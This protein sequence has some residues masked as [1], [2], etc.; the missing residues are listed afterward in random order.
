[1][2]TSS[3]NAPLNSPSAIPHGAHWVRFNRFFGDAMMI[4][5]A[6]APLRAAGLPLVAWGPAAVIDLFDGSEGFVAVVP[7]PHR[8]YSPWHAA[9]MLRAHRPASIINFPKSS[10]ALLAARLARVPKRLG[11]AEG[12]GWAL[13]THTVSFYRQDTPFVERYAGVVRRAFPELAPTPAFAPFRPRP[14]AFDRAKAQAAQ[15]RFRGPYVVFAPGANS[16]AKRLSVDAFATLGERLRGEGLGVVVLGAGPRDRELVDRLR[17][18]LPEALDLVDRC[19]LSTSAAW[20]CGAKG[21]VGMD[22][23]LAHVAAAAGI[24]TLSVFGP[25]RPR[26][27][28]PAGPRSRV[29]RKTELACLECMTFFCPVSGHPCMNGWEAGRLWRELEVTLNLGIP[30]LESASA[31]G[32]MAFE[33]LPPVSRKA[34]PDERVARP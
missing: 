29:I 18:R 23:G 25:T 13:S 22:S 28:Q 24:P 5:A 7:E 9:D 31:A 26:H 8:K 6:I 20:I 34:H 11:C 17:E 30:S 14:A 4:H 12:G 3:G 2:K 21:L 10:R 1:M 16:D 33:F 15:L 32:S 27:S 19:D